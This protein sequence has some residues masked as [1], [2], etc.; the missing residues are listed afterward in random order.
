MFY[1]FFFF[2]FIIL[3]YYSPLARLVKGERNY[4]PLEGGWGV[5]VGLA[6]ALAEAEPVSLKV[7]KTIPP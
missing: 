2:N 6:I 1:L 4:S 3:S 5:L 7:K